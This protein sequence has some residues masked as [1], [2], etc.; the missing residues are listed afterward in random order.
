MEKLAKVLNGFIC[1]FDENKKC[2]DCPYRTRCSPQ[3]ECEQLLFDAQDV[4]TE[5]LS[6]SLARR[7]VE[8][9]QTDGTS[10][11]KPA[12]HLTCNDVEDCIYLLDE[13]R[14]ILVSGLC[15]GDESDD[16]PEDQVSF[17]NDMRL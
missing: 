15:P 12:K 2:V 4:Y 14:S 10:A 13:L 7:I 1:C 17:T 5:L 9:A 11:D 8:A 3:D 6:G 16:E